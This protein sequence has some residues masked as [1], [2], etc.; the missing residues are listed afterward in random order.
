MSCSPQ[1]IADVL[2]DTGSGLADKIVHNLGNFTVALLAIFGNP[3]RLALAGTG[4]LVA[5]GGAHYILT[6]RHV[7]DEVLVGA[8]HVGITLKPE[9]NHR[10]AIPSRDF[11]PVGLPKPCAWN[12]WGP[13]MIP[14]LIPAERVGTIEAYRSFWNPDRRVEVYAEVIE[15]LVLMGTPAEL[16]TIADAQ[17]DLQ[18]TGMYLGPEKL[19]HMG[20]FD[21]LDYEIEHKARLPRHFG[22]VSGGGVWRVWVF[23]SAESGEIDW[24]MSFHG[25]AFYQLNIGSDPTTLRCQGPQSVQA[26]LHTLGAAPV[27]S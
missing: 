3:E 1:E 15:V 8:D 20:G 27:R 13:D 11:A 10:Y 14:L 16:G 12:E 5:I 4:T 2:K 9:V 18:I 6:A 21:Y 7:W 25:V 19:Q 23:C 17:A 22:G 24:K 26:M